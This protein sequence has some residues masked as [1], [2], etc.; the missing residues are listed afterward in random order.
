LFGVD[1]RIST[2]SPN[3]LRVYERNYPGKAFQL[4]GPPLNALIDR[5]IITDG[6]E[7]CRSKRNDGFITCLLTGQIFGG[8]THNTLDKLLNHSSADSINLPRIKVLAP[9]SIVPEYSEGKIQV[10]PTADGHVSESEYVDKYIRSDVVLLP[11][12]QRTY[13]DTISG[14]F[15]DSVT[16]G[17]IPLVTK[18]TSMAHA[19]EE[20]GL[21]ALAIDWDNEF[22]WAVVDN[23]MSNASIRDKCRIMTE[24]FRKR[25]RNASLA[26]SIALM[27]GAAIEDAALNRK[28]V[29]PALPGWP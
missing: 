23:I 25:Y 20:F 7:K 13:A 11:Y 12:S 5:L 14:I 2:Y 3:I 26:Q 17:C 21:D 24:E 6:I 1:V 19:L 16:L 28:G 4:P 10:I 27:V 18:N 9:R 8:K 15:V 22:S 29:P